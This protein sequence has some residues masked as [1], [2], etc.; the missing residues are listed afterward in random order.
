[1]LAAATIPALIPEAYD[2][3]EQA[4]IKHRLLEAYLQKLFLIVGTSVGSGGSIEL[5]YVDCFAGPWGDESGTMESTS[6]AISL[7]TLDACRQA[8]EK[9]RVSATIRALYVE[10]SPK[11]FA[12]LQ[13]FLKSSTPTGI[14]TECM[15]GDFV[16]LRPAILDWVGPRAFGFF[17][18]DPMGWKA[19]GT[20][21]LKP[22]LQRA[23]SE[24]LINFMYNDVNRMASMR[25]WQSDLAELLG[26]SIDVTGL[27]PTD[28]E[29]AIVRTY[30][31]NLKRC[32]S[33][34][35]GY[36]ARAAHVRVLD[37]EKERPK[38]HL[39]Y[40]TTH[41]RGVVE[42]MDISE[43]VDL[44]QKQ[45]R[46]V[47]KD[48]KKQ[49]ETGTVDMFGPDSLVD[50]MAG[51]VS[52]EDVDAFWLNYLRRGPRM[53]DRAEFADILEEKDWFPGDLQTSLVRLIKAGKVINLTAGA[54][55]SRRPKLPLHFGIKGGEQLG[56]TQP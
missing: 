23:H 45:V 8:L 5:C 55:A 49:S 10:A 44:I 54:A 11:S 29:Q 15:R 56:L 25:E 17:F 43:D 26:E 1:M 36:R 24:F 4:L 39:V 41:P 32:V 30:R 3:R 7:R 18:I 31:E 51:H 35:N 33:P 53:V 19:I 2:G 38:Y 50:P 22:L 20:P 16:E 46:A 40:V 52:P 27:S 48:S 6:I 21:T 42:F 9:Q 14:L 12:R 47:K 34:N 37:P 28:R 13:A